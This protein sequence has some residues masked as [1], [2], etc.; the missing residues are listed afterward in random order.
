MWLLIS[1]SSPVLST[2][3]LASGSGD[4]TVK[5]WDPK[6][7]RERATLTGHGE[8]ISALAFAPRARHL[9][10]AGY[11]GTDPRPAVLPNTFVVLVVNK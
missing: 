1:L 4:N 6:T 9:L 11:D 8:G 2:F 7:G 3:L 10:T 5:L